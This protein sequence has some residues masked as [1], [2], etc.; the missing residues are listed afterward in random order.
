ML[1]Y[2]GLN[3]NTPFSYA[4]YTRFH[5]TTNQLST[6]VQQHFAFSDSISN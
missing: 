6:S 2:L 4:G 5:L 1:H 3:T